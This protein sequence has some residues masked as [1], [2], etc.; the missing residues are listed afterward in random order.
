MIG[1]LVTS[2]HHYTV[3]EYLAQSWGCRFKDRMRV[4]PY[5]RILNSRRLPRASYI[6]SD[7]DRLSPQTREM[8]IVD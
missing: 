8:A 2:K 1:Y 6:F 5:E 7:I 4:L 3:S